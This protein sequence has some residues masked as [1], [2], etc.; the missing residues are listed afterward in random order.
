MLQSVVNGFLEIHQQTLVMLSQLEAEKQQAQIRIGSLETEIN[1]HRTH[2][3][4]LKD[5]LA[6][7]CQRQF[8]DEEIYHYGRSHLVGYYILNGPPNNTDPFP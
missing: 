7:V 1:S 6:A 2:I 5:E 8:N 3:N 4:C